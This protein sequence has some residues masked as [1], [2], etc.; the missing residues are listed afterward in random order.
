MSNLPGNIATPTLVTGK[1]DKSQVVDVYDSSGIE[2]KAQNMINSVLNAADGTILE[3]TKNAAVRLIDAKNFYADLGGVINK[4]AEGGFSKDALKGALKDYKKG[5]LNS[6]LEANGV[7]DLDKLKDNLLGA[8]QSNVKEF[9]FGAVKGF[10]DN[11]SPG[12]LDENGIKSFADAK[13]LYDNMDAMVSDFSK[14]NTEAWIEAGTPFATS[15]SAGVLEKTLSILDETLGTGE[16][17][18]KVSDKELDNAILT[19]ICKGLVVDNS[20]VVN[21]FIFSSF[22]DLTQP[23]NAEKLEMFVST[24]VADAAS[25]GS[26]DFLVKAAGLTSPSFVRANLKGK[27]DDFLSNMQVPICLNETDRLKA[28]QD[29]LKSM[30]IVT[31]QMEDEIDLTMYSKVSKDAKQVLKFSAEYAAEVAISEGLTD[32]D[33]MKLPDMFPDYFW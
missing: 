10:T 19:G 13:K 4:F 21:D 17:S 9:A 31:G 16:L 32:Y 5:A 27:E 15:L 3:N 29:I 30:S 8:V 23:A 11:L 26:S 24:S 33:P 7:K 12:L 2:A 6:I 20:P 28:E 1:T 18:A 14:M 22:G 25:V